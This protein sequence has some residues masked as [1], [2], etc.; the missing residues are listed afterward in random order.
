MEIYWLGHSCFRLRGRDAVVLTDPCPPTTGYKIGRVPANIVTISHDAPESSYR[1]AVTG[2]AKFITGPGEYEISSVMI[3]GVRTR[4]AKSE[5]KRNVAYVMEIDDVKVCHLGDID[6]VPAG[7]D[8]E[9]LS[10]AD[11][12]LLPVGGGSTIDSAAAAE[13]VSMLEPSIVIPMKYRTEASTGELEPV[14][15]FLKE[16]GVENHEVQPR[17]SIT[18]SGLPSQT[19]V[20]LLNYRG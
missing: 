4:G 2:D 10:N 16:M 17:L 9:R 20:A 11:I 18:K 5:R 13:I 7:D 8:V 15:R 6:H 1:Q 12:L 19:T 3:A 14:D